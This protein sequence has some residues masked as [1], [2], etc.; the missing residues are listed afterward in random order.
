MTNLENL[1]RSQLQELYK[2]LL[3]YKN[4]SKK[5]WKRGKTQ[6]QNKLL[7]KDTFVVEYH[8]SLEVW[9]VED[10]AKSVF[11]KV[12]GKT[13]DKSEI[14]FQSSSSLLGGMKIYWNDFLVDMSFLKFYNKIK[15]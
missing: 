14:S 9:Y 11:Q 7:W 6:F 2:Q 8:P 3:E 1:D 15:K 5:L 10:Q 4:L 13:P 12:F